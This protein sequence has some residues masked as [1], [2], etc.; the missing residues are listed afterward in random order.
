[1]P[2]DAILAERIARRSKAE[3][4]ARAI[5]FLLQKFQLAWKDLGNYF[6]SKNTTGTSLNY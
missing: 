2:R 1:M 3:R 5:T 6:R 4:F